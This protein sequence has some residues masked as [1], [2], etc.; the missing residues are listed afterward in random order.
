MVDSC[1]GHADGLDQ[2]FL[3][4]TALPASDVRTLQFYL[5]DL[6]ARRAQTQ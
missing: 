1:D 2:V 4:Y 6:R 3:D 5:G